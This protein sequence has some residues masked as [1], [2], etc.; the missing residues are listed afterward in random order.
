MEQG[1][2]C[3]GPR[4]MKKIHASALGLVA[5]LALV[6]GCDG[7]PSEEDCTKMA[8][9]MVELTIKET[10]DQAG[11]AAAAMAEDMAKSM[12]EGMKPEFK[13]TCMEDGTKSAVQCILKQSTLEDIEKNCK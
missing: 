7:K 2:F 8:D 10:K 4:R 3:Y 6:A 9:K 13:K 1:G 11:E 12:A 5:A